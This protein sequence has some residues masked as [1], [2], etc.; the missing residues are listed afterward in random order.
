[1]DGNELAHMLKMILDLTA[2]PLLTGAAVSLMAPWITV[3]ML[4]RLA[5][6]VTGVTGTS[7]EYLRKCLKYLRDNRYELI[8]IDEA[9]HRASNNSL[10]RKKWVTFTVDDGFHDQVVT[11][12]SIFQEFD[13]PTT[14]FLVT[15]LIDGE[16]WPWDYQLM[17]VAKHAHAQTIEIEVAGATHRIAMGQ[18]ETKHTLLKVGRLSASSNVSDVVARIARLS[19]VKLPP[20]PPPEMRPASWDDVREAEKRGMRFGAHS[21]SHYILSQVNDGQLREE[22]E[23]SIARV[24]DECAN[25]SEVFCYPS[26]KANEFDRR[27][28]NIVQRLGFKGALSAEPGYLDPQQMRQ[29]PSYRFAIPR[30]PLPNN[31]DDFKLYLS[32]MQ[33]Q[34]EKLTNSPLDTLLN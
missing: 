10:P 34:R 16:L 32:W 8:S 33:R 3:L 12:S 26:G 2:H 17:Y 9:I 15:G 4:H 29:Y 6:P 19:G 7:P 11:A 22:I 1:M 13:C 31:F 18:A 24:R 14:Y 28:I 30:L 25:P 27:A 23:S 5:N 20:A 21:V